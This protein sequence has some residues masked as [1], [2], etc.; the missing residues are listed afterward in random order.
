MAEACVIVDTT[1]LYFDLLQRLQRAG[2]TVP[3]TLITPQYRGLT[4]EQLAQ[5]ASYVGAGRVFTVSGVIA[6]VD[7]RWRAFKPARRC[8]NC[9]HREPSHIG[10]PERR[11]FREELHRIVE[12]LELQERLIVLAD[13]A[14][15]HFARFGPVDGALLALARHLR[16]DER[17]SVLLVTADADLHKECGRMDIDA[18]H[19]VAPIE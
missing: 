12:H 11:A 19:I 15:E 8:T 14:V 7:R 4:P 13:I 9:G 16:D 1:V 6:E 3:R 5:I 18:A 17:E 10:N 2:A